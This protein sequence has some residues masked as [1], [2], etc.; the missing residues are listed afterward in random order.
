M[1]MIHICEYGCGQEAKHQFKNGKW[2]C[3][4]HYSRCSDSRKKNRESHLGKIR[5]EESKRKQ[6]ISMSGENH[7]RG[8]LGK[9]H[10]EETRKRQSESKSGEN[11]PRGMLGKHHSKE[12]RKNMG[13]IKRIPFGNL[14]KFTENEGYELLSKEED[15]KNQFSYLWFRCPEGHEFS[16]RWDSFK[17]GCRCKECFAER[18]KQRMLNGGAAFAISFIQ[19]PSGPQVELFNLVKENHPEAIMN[20]VC[21]NYSIDIVISSSKIAIEYDGSYWH[22]DQEA[23]NKRQKEIEKEGWTFLRY[24][25][26]VPS[27]EELKKDI[28]SLL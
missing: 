7:P 3:S 5:S 20:Y 18:Q 19:N 2:C 28:L 21:L 1:T 16:M 15:Y 9:H 8:M 17:T 12:T 4:E 25:D 6:S 11:H 27:K 10:S 26:Y 13:N 14:I 22:Q 24:R 23:D